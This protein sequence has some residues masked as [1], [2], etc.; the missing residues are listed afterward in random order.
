VDIRGTKYFLDTSLLTRDDAQYACKVLNMTLVEFEDV[1]RYKIIKSWLR[2][3][4]KNIILL[5]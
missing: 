2:D 5:Y 1:G 4:G 3:N